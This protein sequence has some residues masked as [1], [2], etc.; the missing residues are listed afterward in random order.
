MKNL[1]LVVKIKEAFIIAWIPNFNIMRKY[2][3]IIFVIFGLVALSSCQ[4]FLDVVPDDVATLS[5]AFSTRHEAEKY[6]YTCYSFIQKNGD[7]SDD[8]GMEGGDE[9]WAFPNTG[10]YFYIAQ[11]F[12]NVVS[13]Y[14]NRW[15]RV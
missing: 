13:P 6:L 11:G 1:N 7:L 14:G 4:K 12:Q 3:I 2:K 8:P 5:N 15:G 10:A 9:I